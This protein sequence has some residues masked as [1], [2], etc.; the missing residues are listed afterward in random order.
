MSRILQVCLREKSKLKKIIIKNKFKLK[1]SFEFLLQQFLYLASLKIIRLLLRLHWGR[2]MFGLITNQKC[3]TVK[4]AKFS[5]SFHVFLPIFNSC[6]FSLN[7]ILSLKLVFVC[8]F[9]CCCIC[10][11]KK[12][13]TLLKITVFKT[14]RMAAQFY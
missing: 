5:Q 10:Y 1:N 6:L 13:T 9:L 2:N 4:M 11:L 3:F 12:Y 14:L 8:V 7:C